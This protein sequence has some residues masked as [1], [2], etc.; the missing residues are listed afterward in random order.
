MSSYVLILKL[1]RASLIKVGALGTFKFPEGNYAYAG[2]GNLSRIKRHLRREKRLRWHIDYL[3][4]RAQ[5]VE[6]WIGDL[7]EYLLVEMLEGKLTPFIK[8]FGSS[9]TGKYSHL[10]IGKPEREFL[11]SIGYKRINSVL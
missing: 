8:G 11:A 5:P 9:D 4:Q 7:E 3:L 10:F 1:D 2:S 6:V